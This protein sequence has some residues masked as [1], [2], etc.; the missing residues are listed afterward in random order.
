MTF[1]CDCIF[2][3]ASDLERSI[4]F[5]SEVHGCKFLWRDVVARFDSDGVLWELVPDSP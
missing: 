3:Y 1:H 5:Y 2:Y 4:R